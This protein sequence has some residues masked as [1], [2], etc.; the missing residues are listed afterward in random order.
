MSVKIVI[1]VDPGLSGAIAIVDSQ[2]TVL[3]T[4]VMTVHGHEMD[5][6]SLANWLEAEIESN[7][8]PVPI[9]ACIEKVSAMP[10][11]GVKSM[12]TFGFN[13]G[14]I[15]GILASFS[16][17]R[18]MVTPQIWQKAVLS[19]TNRGDKQA[20]VNFCRRIYP[21]LNLLA[22]ERSKK[23]H[24]GMADAICIARY[25]IMTLL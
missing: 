17:P 9:I 13:T 16:I 14:A 18:Y 6:T 5:L 25:A 11:Q 4:T 10:H 23:P 22:T 7:P 21:D 20:S 2:Y 15:H 24:T 19:F 12:F 8:Y 1:G 3:A